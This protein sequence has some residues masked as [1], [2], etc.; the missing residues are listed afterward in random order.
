[1]NLAGGC[2]LLL[3]LTLNVLFSA[4]WY[5]FNAK[6]FFLRIKIDTEALVSAFHLYQLSNVASSFSHPEWLKKYVIGWLTSTFDWSCGNGFT[7]GLNPTN[8]G[9]WNWAS[10]LSNNVA[11][12]F[13][14]MPVHQHLRLQISHR[15]TVQHR[16]AHSCDGGWGEQWHCPELLT[17]G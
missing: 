3:F 5:Q 4:E 2:S 16:G 9:T 17:K 12:H 8:K 6:L 15:P 13:T 11:G 7:R 1:M 14:N 10:S